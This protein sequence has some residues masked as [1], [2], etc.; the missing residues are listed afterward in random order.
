[1]ARE[2]KHTGSGY[3]FKQ[4]RITLCLD[5]AP[6]APRPDESSAKKNGLSVEEN[7]N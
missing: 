3:S 2:V 5:T 6:S 7:D 1:M 4:G